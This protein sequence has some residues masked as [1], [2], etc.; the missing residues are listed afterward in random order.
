MFNDP[1]LEDMHALLY[2]ENTQVCYQKRQLQAFLN[3]T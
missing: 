1:W 2:F 3:S